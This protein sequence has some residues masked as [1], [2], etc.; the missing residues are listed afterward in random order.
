MMPQFAMGMVRAVWHHGGAIPIDDVQH[1][2][3]LRSSSKP[4]SEETKLVE[5]QNQGGIDNPSVF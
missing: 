5:C 4:T 3:L 1:D 2:A